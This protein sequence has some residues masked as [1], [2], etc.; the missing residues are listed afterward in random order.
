MKAVLLVLLFALV[1]QGCAE[2][3]QT[4]VFNGCTEIE[5]VS[6]PAEENGSLA[7]DDCARAAGY[8]VDYYELDVETRAVVTVTMQSDAFAQSFL[9]VHRSDSDV[10]LDGDVQDPGAPSA[11]VQVVLEPGA[12]YIIGAS[13]LNAGDAGDYAL[14][15]TEE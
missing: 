12:P 6:V 9:S 4:A 3:A 2:P 13:G 1:L 7:D 15:V 8:P 14:T 5:P 11:S 10:Q